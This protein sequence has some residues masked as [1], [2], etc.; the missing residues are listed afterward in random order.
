MFDTW[1]S[2]RPSSVITRSLLKRFV[3]CPLSNYNKI[4]FWLKDSRTKNRPLMKTEFVN[5]YSLNSKYSLINSFIKRFSWGN[6]GIWSLLSSNDENISERILALILQW[7]L[8]N[9][10][11]KEFKRVYFYLKTTI[12]LILNLQLMTF[13]FKII[14]RK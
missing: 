11:F 3:G 5:L 1:V 10:F 8:Q 7:I 14:I 6:F 4:I 2:F 13:C 9:C 12:Y